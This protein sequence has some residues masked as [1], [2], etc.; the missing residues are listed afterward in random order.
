[1]DRERLIMFVLS[2]LLVRKMSHL[3]HAVEIDMASIIASFTKLVST[4]WEILRRLASM[5]KAEPTIQTTS[6]KIESSI[7]W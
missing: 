1:M 2:C 3:G 7:S 5:I 6:K 4:Y